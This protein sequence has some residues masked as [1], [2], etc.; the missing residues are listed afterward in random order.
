MHE[1]ELTIGAELVRRL[2]DRS[3][4]EYADLPLAPLASSGSSNAL[5]RLGDEL[6]VRLPRQPGQ[7]AAIEKEARWLPLI[8]TSLSTSVPEVVALGGP[9][10][11]YPETWAVTR[12]IDGRPPAVPWDPFIPGSSRGLALDLASFVTELRGIAVPSVARTDPALRSYRGGRLADLDEDFRHWVAACRDLPTLGLDLEHALVV[13]DR[14]V[15]ADLAAQ[16]EVK[17]YHGDLLAEN[18]LVRDGRLAAVLD[19]GGLAVGDTTVDLVVAWEV[20]D[21]DGRDVFWQALGVGDTARVRSM[22]WSLAIAMMSFPYYWSS[23]PARCTAR[24]SMAASVLT[25][26]A[27]WWPSDCSVPA[28]K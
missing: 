2:V 9:G 23:M 7:S 26:A 18:L 5:F 24:R 1:D 10:D 6:I 14:A 11:G 12:W 22:G 21:D 4:P 8:A 16:P 13:W 27:E 28:P 17:W 25:A 3:F 19:F 15:A 20:L